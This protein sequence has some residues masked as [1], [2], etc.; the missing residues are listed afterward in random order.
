MPDWELP[1]E[2]I[3]ADL[4]EQFKSVIPP[5]KKAAV[6]TPPHLL[7]ADAKPGTVPRIDVCGLSCSF[8]LAY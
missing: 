7:S 1:D 3:L 5:K 2:D 6:T 8:G 4:P